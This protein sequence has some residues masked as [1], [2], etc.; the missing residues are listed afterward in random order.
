[1]KKNK[2][3]KFNKENYIF[4]ALIFI[5]AYL[6]GACIYKFL[7]TNKISDCAVELFF[8]IVLS[9]LVAYAITTREQRINKFKG[10]FKTS[11]KP[12][13]VDRMKKYLI[14]SIFISLI[15]TTSII[16]LVSTDIIY[17]NLYNYSLSIPLLVILSILFIFV[18]S[19][20]IIFFIYYEINEN[21]VRKSK[22]FK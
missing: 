2:K 15:I 6:L 8:M 9:C 1:M 17:V 3:K 21:V 4:I 19:F 16:V 12:K 20:V 18:V 11:K 22:Y 5:Y 7:D 14:N 13:K 10:L